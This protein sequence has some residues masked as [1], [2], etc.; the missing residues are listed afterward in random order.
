MRHSEMFCIFYSLRSILLEKFQKFEGSMSI[1][2][3]H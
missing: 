1:L 2:E 3:R